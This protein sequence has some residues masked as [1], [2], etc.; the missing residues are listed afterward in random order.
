[1]LCSH[2]TH[3]L[4]S[5]YRILLKMTLHGFL[6]TLDYMRLKR[7]ITFLFIAISWRCSTDDSR[8]NQSCNKLIIP[9]CPINFCHYSGKC[10]LYLK[11]IKLSR[12]GW[13]D[14]T[15]APALILVPMYYHPVGCNRLVS[16]EIN[17]WVTTTIF[18]SEKY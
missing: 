14:L 10:T 15:H 7:G 2:Y 6:S 18:L 16:H 9:F 3:S 11:R 1:M 13:R 12:V 8:T 5:T 4:L 17:L